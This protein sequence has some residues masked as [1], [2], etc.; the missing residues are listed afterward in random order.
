M[1]KVQ[2][3]VS[4]SLP[5]VLNELRQALENNGFT[6][7]E[8]DRIVIPVSHDTLPLGRQPQSAYFDPEKEIDATV[9]S[10]YVAE[11]D[12]KVQ[13]DISTGEITVLAPLDRDETG[14]LTN[15]VKTPE[16]KVR[17]AAVADRV[18]EIEL[19]FG[20]AGQSRVYSP[21]ERGIDFRVPV[22]CVMENGQL[23]EFEGTFLL[24][25]SWKLSAKDASLADDYNPLAPPT[26]QSGTLD[27]G[28]RGEVVAEAQHGAYAPNFIA[29]LHQQVI[30]LGSEGD[31]TPESLVAWLDRHI[32][33]RDIPQSE[34][35][36]FLL[37]VVRGLR[38]RFSGLDVTSLARDRFRLRDEIERRINQHRLAA[39]R[40]AFQDFL[41]PQSALTVSDEYTFDFKKAGYEPSWLYEGS[42]QFKHHYFPKPGELHELTP[43]GNL[44]EE[45]KCAQFIDGLD[46]VT[47]WVRNLSR[48][49]SS[50]RFQT[51]TDWFY[52]DFICQLNDGRLLAVEYKGDDIYTAIDAA[53]K[54]AIGAVWESRSDGR[55]LFVMPTKG[56]FSS[57]LKKIR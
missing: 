14:L 39:R 31:W 40:E 41:L 44:K 16:A 29:M 11:L 13:I 4:E 1:S 32:D 46:D 15:C 50:F 28:A 52:P 12:G 3:S 25:Q 54:R 53:E 9:A 21:F 23:F 45:F 49:P 26:G 47:H 42:F 7:A 56:D 51:A 17:V 48:K 35:A 36:A 43:A 18:R 20:G 22:M 38:T 10:V 33:H 34:S 37:K 55:C 6:R 24:D 57:I 2:F 19:T 8:A 27:V 30:A 5:E